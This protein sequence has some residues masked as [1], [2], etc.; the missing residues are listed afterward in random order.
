MKKIIIGL[1][2]AI[3]SS[4]AFAADCVSLDLKLESERIQSI[5]GLS[6]ERIGLH[7]DILK[8]AKTTQILTCAGLGE[9]ISKADATF[10]LD[11]LKKNR[12]NTIKSLTEQVEQNKVILQDTNISSS[13]RYFYVQAL[14]LNSE[15]LNI[16]LTA[17]DPLILR[18]QKLSK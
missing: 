3:G 18:I 4:F 2:L 9:D 7:L 5:Q 17:A 6:Q 1:S 12:L 11:E 8:N 15:Q 16:L 14:Q 10:V 13:K